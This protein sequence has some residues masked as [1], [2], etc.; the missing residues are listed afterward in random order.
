[1]V[2]KSTLLLHLNGILRSDGLVKVF[3]RPVDN[4][5]LRLVRKKVGLVFQNPDD[6]LFSPT[7]FYDVA[8]VPINL[9]YPE[10]EVGQSVAKALDWVG[11]KGYE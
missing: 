3:G 1:M 6:Q 9:G 2:P 4:E 10:T 5:N 8:F 11:M 7:V